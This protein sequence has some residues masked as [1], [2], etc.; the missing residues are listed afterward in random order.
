MTES[1][2]LFSSASI[3]E[4]NPA[5]R[6]SMSP[7]LSDSAEDYFRE[8]P[9]AGASSDFSPLKRLILFSPEDNLAWF[10]IR[11][12]GMRGDMFSYKQHSLSTEKTE[13]TRPG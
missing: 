12:T 10:S 11:L 3:F 5:F 2:Q 8:R 1:P 6:F 7:H 9:A 13:A 4:V